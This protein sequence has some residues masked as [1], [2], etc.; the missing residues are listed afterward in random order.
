MAPPAGPAAPPTASTPRPHTIPPL[1][2]AAYAAAAAH[3]TVSWSRAQG[4]CA[5]G[6]HGCVYPGEHSH[7]RQMKYANARGARFVVTVDSTDRLAL[8]DMEGGPAEAYG[9]ADAGRVAAMVREV[10]STD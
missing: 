4:C 9:G 6:P 2:E 7:K 1:G 8:K 3:P 10:L 5:K